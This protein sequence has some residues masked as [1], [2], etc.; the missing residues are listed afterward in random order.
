MKRSKTT[1]IVPTAGTEQNGPH[2]VLGKHGYV[3]NFTA[4]AIAQSLDDTLVAPTVETV[5]QGSIDPPE[6]HMAFPGTISVPAKVF[7]LIL[8]HTAQPEGT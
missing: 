5:P 8:E 2:A 4:L 1:I 3:V 7:E 6:G